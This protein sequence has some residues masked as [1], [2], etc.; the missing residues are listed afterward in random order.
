[1][2]ALGVF[3]PLVLTALL[4]SWHNPDIRNIGLALLFTWAASNAT[5]I[6]LPFDYRPILY[7]LLQ[8]MI[9][10]TAAGG[11][12]VMRFTPEGSRPIEGQIFAL[13]VV[14]VALANTAAAINYSLQTAPGFN[15]KYLFVLLTN[16]TFGAECIL[17]GTW[18]V[19]DAFA[20]AAGVSRVFRRVG[21][22]PS[23]AGGTQEAGTEE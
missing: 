10:L 5:A 11:W 6:F 9:G 13:A 7:P 18:G 1:M 16:L 22:N 15:D 17:V 12:L 8:V 21:G 14:I 2:L 23:P 3:L 19:R 20:R 4:V